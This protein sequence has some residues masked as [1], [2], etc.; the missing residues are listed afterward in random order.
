MKLDPT[1]T[2]ALA[3]LLT[4]SLKEE[5]L[6]Q[7]HKATGKGVDSLR[8]EIL[9]QAENIQINIFGEDYLGF[10]DSGRKAGKMPNVGAIIEWVKIKR[11]ALNDKEAKK[12]GWAIA[13][14]MKRIGMHSDR[15]RPPKVDLT[16]RHF[17][18]NVIEDKKEDIFEALYKAIDTQFSLAVNN[19][20]KM[21][22]TTLEL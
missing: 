17:I 2:K 14:S 12:I 15:G 16:K 11:I 7:E 3:D 6:A 4:D 1:I 5:L 13:I 20:T 8:T 22:K 18:K 10:Q 19:L 21:K 9:E